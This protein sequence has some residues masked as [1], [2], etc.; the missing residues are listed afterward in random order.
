MGARKK[1]KAN[2]NKK[3]LVLLCPEKTGTA[4]YLALAGTINMKQSGRP[5]LKCW[6]R[7]RQTQWRLVA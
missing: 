1:E 4:T 5:D 3:A 7:Y 6:K 2:I